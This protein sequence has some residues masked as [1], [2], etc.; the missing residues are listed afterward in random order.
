VGV[1]AEL[2][3]AVPAAKKF[4]TRL[5]KLE[6]EV[7]KLREENAALKAELGVFIDRW[8]TL[9]G[10]ALDI[11]RY[12]VSKPQGKPAEMATANRVNIQIVDTYLKQLVTGSYVEAVK[13]GRTTTFAIAPKGKW[14]LRE[15][16]L[17]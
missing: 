11:L 7:A 3:K 17:L 8:E 5:E 12:L 4:Q 6:A 10:D 9:D 2:L 15:R 14:Y 13:K 16:N 1:T